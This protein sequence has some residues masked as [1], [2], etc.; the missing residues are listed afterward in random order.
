MFSL[1]LPFPSPPPLFAQLDRD[2]KY[3]RLMLAKA[4]LVIQYDGMYKGS[5]SGNAGDLA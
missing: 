1:P 2:L 5:G 4:T 3:V